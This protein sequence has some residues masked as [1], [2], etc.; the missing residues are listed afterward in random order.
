MGSMGTTNHNRLRQRTVIDVD[1]LAIAGDAENSSTFGFEEDTDLDD[2][3][4]QFA[5]KSSSKAAAPPI[6]T[7][8][9]IISFIDNGLHGEVFGKY[10]FYFISVFRYDCRPANVKYYVL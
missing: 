3:E 1:E 7:P 5:A 8:P 9:R 4:A 6:S 10:I 2:L